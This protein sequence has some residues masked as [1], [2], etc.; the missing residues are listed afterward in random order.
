MR[1]YLSKN[2]LFLICFMQNVSAVYKE[3]GYVESPFGHVHYIKTWRH[4]NLE[5]AVPILLCL[6]RALQGPE[7]LFDISINYPVILCTFLEAKKIAGEDLSFVEKIFSSLKN[8]INLK[9]FYLLG[10]FNEFPVLGYYDSEKEDIISCVIKAD[11]QFD[12]VGWVFGVREI[13]E[14]VKIEGKQK[15]RHL[16]FQIDEERLEIMES[17]FSGTFPLSAF[18]FVENA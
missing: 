12:V 17:F 1:F 9:S 2:L 18:V 11:I 14:K 3:S 7:E 13:L 15:G 4:K 16:N 6:D 5:H 8:Q 10:S